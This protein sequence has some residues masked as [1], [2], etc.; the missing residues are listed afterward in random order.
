MKIYDEI[1]GTEITEP[2]LEA[3]FVYDRV[4]VIGRTEETTEVMPGTVTE[5]CPDGL[6]RRVPAEDI[7]EPCQWYHTY[8]ADEL[9]AQQPDDDAPL[10]GDGVA[11]WDELAAAYN[12]GVRLA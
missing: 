9:A 2:D 10:P 8:T 4:R 1:T 12:E 3:G 6:R 5:D 11:T 7:I